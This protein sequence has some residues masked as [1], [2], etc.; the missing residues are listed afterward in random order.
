MNNAEGLLKLSQKVLGSTITN[1]AIKH[2]FFQH[3]CAGMATCCSLPCIPQRLWDV[4]ARVLP[5]L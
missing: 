4:Q 2:T 5:G 1:G 3:F